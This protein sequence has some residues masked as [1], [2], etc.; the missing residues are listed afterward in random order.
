VRTKVE[1]FG[2]LVGVP[3]GYRVLVDARQLHRSRWILGQSDLTD[4]ELAFLATGQLREEP[5]E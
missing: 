5:S 3:S 1:G 2:L 4:A